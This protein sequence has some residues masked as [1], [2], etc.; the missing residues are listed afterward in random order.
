MQNY[1]DQTSDLELV[2]NLAIYERS[3]DSSPCN[4]FIDAFK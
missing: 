2:A 4:V 1:L 3:S